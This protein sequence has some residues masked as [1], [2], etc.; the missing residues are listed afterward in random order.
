M[1]ASKEDNV[2]KAGRVWGIIRWLLIVLGPLAVIFFLIVVPWF[3]TYMLTAHSYHFRDPNDGKTPQDFGMAYQ[4]AD[5]QSSDGI[6]LKGWYLPAA[7]KSAASEP[8]A[9]SS[10]PAGTI[11]YCH[12]VNRTRIEMLPMAQFAHSLGYNGLVFDFRHEGASGGAI[13]TIGYQERLDVEGAVRYVLDQ[14]HAAQ[15]VVLWGVSM[16]AAAALMAAAETPE[17]AAVVSDSTFLTFDDTVQHH[18]KL[19]V[20]GPAFPITDEVIAWAGLR[21]HFRPS[22]F[23]LRTAVEHINPRPILFV[24]VEGDKRMPPA[25]ARTL[26]DLATSSDKMLVVLPGNRHGEGFKSGQDQYEQAVKQFL[27]KVKAGS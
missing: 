5:F 25:I 26:Y 3:F 8:S 9:G 23:D 6:N 19:Y 13:S 27:R 12:G 14:Q 1:P 10:A 11:I 22:D 24:A 21:G 18:W 16:G 17:P 15:P 2:P 7:S 20:G 4:P